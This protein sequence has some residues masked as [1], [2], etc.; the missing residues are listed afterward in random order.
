VALHTETTEPTVC[1]AT[2]VGVHGVK[3]AVKARLEVDKDFLPEEI[4]EVWLLE[5]AGGRVPALLSDFRVVPQGALVHVVG[6]LTPEAAKTLKGVELHLPEAALTMPEAADEV[7]DV[8]DVT[9]FTVHD[10]Q[11]GPLGT[12]L[13]LMPRA[14]QPLLVIECDLPAHLG[15]EILVPWHPNLITLLDEPGRELHLDLPP[16]LVALYL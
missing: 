1:I 6:Y 7:V 10:A 15:T 2:I 13:A 8:P 16:G 3:G 12:V 5:T 11:Y 4:T 9:G 14:S